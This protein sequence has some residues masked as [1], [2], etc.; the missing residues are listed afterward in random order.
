MP[1]SGHRRSPG[2]RHTDRRPQS[3]APG[4]APHPTGMVDPRRSSHGLQLLPLPPQPT[5][6]DTL[7]AG[8]CPAPRGV[9]A[10]SDSATRPTRD[11]SEPATPG[12][13]G[14]ACRFCSWT[15]A[16]P[17]AMRAS[18]S[19]AATRA[20][21]L[22]ASHAGRNTADLAGRCGVRHGRHA[23]DTGQTVRRLAAEHDGRPGLG[24]H[25]AVAEPSRAIG[26]RMGSNSDLCPLTSACDDQNSLRERVPA[27]RTFCPRQ[28]SL[29]A[30]RIDI[31]ERKPKA[32]PRPNTK[33]ANSEL[34][35]VLVHPCRST[36]IE[37]T[38]AASTRT[39]EASRSTVRDSPTRAREATIESA[40]A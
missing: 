5:Q 11:A 10:A 29:S 40:L 18:S 36:P 13:P 30:P 7:R 6:L 37:A 15:S 24:E 31:L 1:S 34:V 26:P 35:R 21:L 39:D 12:T 9:P 27:P 14:T 20:E 28:C 2:P 4:T 23:T 32:R 25:V 16:T 38:R 22:T 17:A 8:Q 33:P 3:R 19:R